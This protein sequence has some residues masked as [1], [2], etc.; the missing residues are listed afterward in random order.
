MHERKYFRVCDMHWFT[1]DCQESRL[2]YFIS[3]KNFPHAWSWQTTAPPRVC[4]SWSSLP[5]KIRFS[6]PTF[7]K[8]F[9]IRHHLMVGVLSLF[10]G[11]VEIWKKPLLSD[12]INLRKEGLTESDNK[13]RASLSLK[14]D[15]CNPTPT[16]KQ[17]S[18]QCPMSNSGKKEL[19]C[20]RKNP[21]AER[22]S[23]RGRGSQE[24]LREKR[25]KTGQKTHCRRKCR[26]EE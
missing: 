1:G 19:P 15:V 23:G 10:Y 22:S 13:E 9:I 12:L 18:L 26:E 3:K 5:V 8:C 16:G 20:N 25:T 7:T 17:C 21:P 4:F 6:L 2:G 11:V 24:R 14:Q